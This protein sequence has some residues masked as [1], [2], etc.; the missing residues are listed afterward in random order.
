MYV[1]IS[2]VRKLNFISMTLITRQSLKGI[3]K[4]VEGRRYR[5]DEVGEPYIAELRSSK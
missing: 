4:E 3:K 5:S 2:A 1:I